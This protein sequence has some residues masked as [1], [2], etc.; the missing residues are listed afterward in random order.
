MAHRLLIH[1]S[2]KE[3]LQALPENIQGRIL[4]A[5]KNKLGEDPRGPWAKKL[6]GEQNLW[7]LRVGDYRV[8]YTMRNDGEVSVLVVRIG[9]RREIYDVLF[10]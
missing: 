5:I 6:K 10:K 9:H 4:S 7:R 1:P 3:D 2:A 8:V